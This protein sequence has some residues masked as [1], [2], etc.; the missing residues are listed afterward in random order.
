MFSAARSLF[1]AFRQLRKSPGFALTVILTLALGI[2]AT[3]AIFS[4]VEGILLR[5]LPFA[6]PDRLV[7]V[8]DQLRAGSGRSITAREIAIYSKAAAAFSSMGAYIGANYELSG[9][10]TPEEV[11]GTRLTAMVFP[12]LGV[13]PLMGRV[14]TQQEDDGHQP[15]AVISYSLWLTRFARDPGIVGRSIDLNRKTYSIIGVMPRDFQF[16][17]QPGRLQQVQIWVPMSLTPTDLSDESAGFWG[18]QMIARLKDGVTVTQASKDA[19]RVAHEVMRGFPASMSALHIT[20]DASLLREFIVGNVRPLLR[21][22]LFAVAI[23]LVIACVNVAGVLLVRAIGRRR[24]YAVRLA[25]GARAGAIIRQSLGEGLLLSVTGGLL[26]LALAAATIRVALHLLPESMPRIDSIYMDSSIVSFDVVLALLSGALCS[27]APAFAAMR[28]NL[29]QSLKDDTRSSSGAS[30]HTWLRSA[31]VV[32]E[33]AIALVLVTVSGAFLR[34]FQKM[35]AVDPGFKPDHMLVARYNMPPS[36]A[37]AETFNREVV[38]RLVGK[39][40]IIAV[41]I[42]NVLPAASN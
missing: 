10:A 13:N 41:G 34:S 8:G 21:T 33:I 18:Y 6:A 30:G 38:D 12:T 28:T 40:G 14:F 29:T 35:R 4:L 22:L 23:V 1:F 31:L 16:P 42:A 9:G 39:P 27:M 26:G 3:T 7:I 32:T 24:E 2:G 25:L 17:P 15:V 37:S 20:G 5:P 19:D 11:S 36:A